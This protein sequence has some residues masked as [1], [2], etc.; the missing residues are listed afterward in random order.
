MSWPFSFIQCLL[1]CGELSSLA[2]LHMHM[3]AQWASL[4]N[5]NNYNN[6]DNDVQNSVRR[7]QGFA[8]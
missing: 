7:D 1:A 3:Y 8:F 2:L 4:P 6:D 5:H